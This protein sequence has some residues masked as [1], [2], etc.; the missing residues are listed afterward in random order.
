M[1]AS[2][3]IQIVAEALSEN[4]PWRVEPVV[5]ADSTFEQ[6]RADDVDK[7][8]IRD[9]IEQ[10]FNFEIRDAPLR[11]WETVQDIIDIVGLRARTSA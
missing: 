5:T 2:R 8:S 4:H 7:L 6:L 9:R 11:S 10:E 1:T 3:I